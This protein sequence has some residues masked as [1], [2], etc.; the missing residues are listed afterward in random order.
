[1][2]WKAK[3][4]SEC[5][6]RRRRPVMTLRACVRQR[7][8]IVIAIY[9]DANTFLLDDFC[10]FISPFRFQTNPENAFA[11]T[12]FTPHFTSFAIS[13]ILFQQI[14][15]IFAS[16]WVARA[17]IKNCRFSAVAL[18]A[19]HSTSSSSASSLVG[20][21]CWAVCLFSLLCASQ[22]NKSNLLRPS[23][24]HA[25]LFFTNTVPL[26]VIG[27][28]FCDECSRYKIEL[29]DTQCQWF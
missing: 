23:H 15:H 5:L 13:N 6:Q 24:S 4:A 11:S 29:Y 26:F 2:R 7:M 17:H 12:H 28:L 27:N 3:S 25:R 21:R 9:A 19:T 16:K 22:F 18:A 20:V 1:M 8:D 14:L 10:C